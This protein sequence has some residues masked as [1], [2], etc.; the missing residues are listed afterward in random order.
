MSVFGAELV[1]VL[2]APPM[3]HTVVEAAP[4]V[5]LAAGEG[6]RRVRLHHQKEG[7]RALW[8]H[9]PAT[10][11]GYDH[12]PT[13]WGPRLGSLG[14]SRAGRTRPLLD[15]ISEILV[16]A[17]LVF[18]NWAPSQTHRIMMEESKPSAPN[19]LSKRGV[20]CHMYT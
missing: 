10:V 11:E 20:R 15:N 12:H 1:G 6:R 18:W 13:T 17:T 7:S 4:I 8:Q 9:Q 3:G 14:A 5:R 2:A 16:S 19:G